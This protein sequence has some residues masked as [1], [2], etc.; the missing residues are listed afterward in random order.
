MAQ[1]YAKLAFH[2]STSSPLERFVSNAAISLSHIRNFEDS[3][4]LV[5]LFPP[6][7]F[8]LTCT[9][10]CFLTLLRFC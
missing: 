8:V 10:L 9:F 3:Y 6:E 1:A 7:L 2:S 5:N 4:K